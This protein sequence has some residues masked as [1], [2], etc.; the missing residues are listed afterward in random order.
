M[1]RSVWVLCLVVMMTASAAAQPAQVQ[2]EALFRQGKELMAAKKFGEACAAFESSFK[3]DANV[4]TLLNHADCR[5]KNGQLVTAWGLFLD[6]ERQTRTASDAAGKQLNTTAKARA[7]K[8]EPK[9]SKL[10]INVAADRQVAG[11]EILRGTEKVEAPAW[12]HPLPVDGGTYKIVARAPS[13][14]EWSTSVTIKTESDTRTIDVP[15]LE[16]AAVATTTTPPTTT[17]PT[18]T[19]DR[20]PPPRETP[21]KRSLVVPLVLGG[22][23]IALGVTAFAV[24]RSGDSIYDDAKHEPDDAKQEALWKSANKRRYAAIGLAAGAVGCLGAA[25]VVYLRG[26]GKEAEPVARRG[27]TIEPVAGPDG[28]PG[29]VVRGAW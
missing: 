14:T 20:P 23:A 13:Y 5:E 18:T 22:A 12:N 3:L 24:S 29:M 17:T 26:G 4:S 10:S 16:P 15:K 21:R 2:A 1:T 28:M 11:L 6:A 9:L 27:V 8:L 7:I 25:I 19:P